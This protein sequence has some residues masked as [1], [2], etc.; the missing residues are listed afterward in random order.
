MSRPRILLADDHAFLLDAFEDL[1]APEF[2]VVGR[3]SDGRA[4]VAAAE[5]LRPDLIVLDISMPLLNG[6]DAAR[7]IKRTL[8]Q[9]KLVF[10]TMHDDADVAAKAAQFGAS[11]YLHKLLAGSDLA[12]TVRKLAGG[13]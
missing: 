2:D 9:I 4:L 8:P 13:G 5:A 6:F 3:V 7:Q 11:A 10:L 12:A 1:L